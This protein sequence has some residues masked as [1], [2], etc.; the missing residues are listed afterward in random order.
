MED[1][2]LKTKSAQEHSSLPCGGFGFLLHALWPH[3]TSSGA[4]HWL[5]VFFRGSEGS[6]C[7]CLTLIWEGGFVIIYDRECYFFQINKSPT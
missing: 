1:G 5:K 7:D 2:N 4:S 6:C 3:V